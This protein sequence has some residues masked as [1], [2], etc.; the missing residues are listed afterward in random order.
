MSN[1]PNVA[2]P[3]ASSGTLVSGEAIRRL[4]RISAAPLDEI[5]AV[6]GS[7]TAYSDLVSAFCRMATCGTTSAQMGAAK[8]LRA[9]ETKTV[10]RFEGF[11]F[12]TK[13][14]TTS[15]FRESVE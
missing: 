8:N 4:C 1:S 2:H 5:D 15:A 7:A 9:R 3:Y 10:K 12:A 13:S 6:A 14:G 11:A